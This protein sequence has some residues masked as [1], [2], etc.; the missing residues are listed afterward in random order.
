MYKITIYEE[1]GNINHEAIL[2]ARCPACAVSNL[3]VNYKYPLTC[4]ERIMVQEYK[5]V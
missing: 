5:E 4:K 2:K 3:L 1:N